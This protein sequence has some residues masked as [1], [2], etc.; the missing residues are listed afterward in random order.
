MTPPRA[1]PMFIANRNTA[2]AASR[3][4]L[5]ATESSSI[6]AARPVDLRRHADETDHRDDDRERSEGWHDRRQPGGGHGGQHDGPSPA[7]LV[8]EVA[9]DGVAEH[10]ARTGH[11]QHEP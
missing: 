10:V 6:A 3:C 2:K 4:W 1:A 11:A 8:G 5:V 7:D 9:T